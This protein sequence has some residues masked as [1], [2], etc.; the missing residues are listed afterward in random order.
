MKNNPESLEISPSEWLSIN[1]FLFEMKQ[2]DSSCVSVYYPYGKGKETI[3]LLQ[4]TK[5]KESTERIESEIE[6]RIAKLRENPS[7]LF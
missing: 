6:K 4:E 7:S 2:I 3:S 1:R 5:R